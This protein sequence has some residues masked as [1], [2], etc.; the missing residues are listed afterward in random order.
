MSTDGPD[1][2]SPSDMSSLLAERGPIHVH[3]GGTAIFDGEPPGYEELLAHVEPPARA[4]PAVPAA[5]PLPARQGDARR[6]GGRSDLRPARATSSTSAVPAPGDDAQLRELVG[7]IMSEP[8][9]QS[10][11]L[12]QLY[13]I[14]RC[15]PGG[16]RGFAADLEDPPRARRRGLRGRRRRDHPRPRSRGD[17]PRPERRG[18]GAAG[19]ADRP[20]CS[21]SA[22]TTRAA[23]SSACP[24]ERRAPGA[25]P[26]RR[27]RRAADRAGLPRPGAHS[28]PVR[29]T[30]LNDEIGR[31]RRVA[32]ASTTLAA[33]KASAAGERHR[34]DGQRRRPGG[35]DRGAAAAVRG[36]G[37][38]ESPTSSRRSSR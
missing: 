24:R 8:L 17:R 21:P 22:S 9:D 3:V 35:L 5:R 32:F 30:F 13:L 11:P 1:Q 6:V 36:A 20:R 7:R 2:L 38:A 14:E 25:R 26:A 29:P 16:E 12:W 15:G 27:R 34:G 4:D 28:D 19:A 31:D 10:R 18:L 37:R 33:L 23:S